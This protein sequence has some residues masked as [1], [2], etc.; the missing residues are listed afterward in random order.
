MRYF[1]CLLISLSFNLILHSQI[2]LYQGNNEALNLLDLT[3]N[4]T[5]K[6][7]GDAFGKLV[8]YDLKDDSL[9]CYFQ[10]RGKLITQKFKSHVFKKISSYPILMKPEFEEKHIATRQFFFS[11]YE[12]NVNGNWVRLYKNNKIA[13]STDKNLSERNADSSRIDYLYGFCHPQ[14]SPTLDKILLEDMDTRMFVGGNNRIYEFDMQ[15]GDKSL[16]AK[17]K[18]ASYSLNGKYILY[19]DNKF[20]TYYLLDKLTKKKLDN[21]NGA[22]AAFWLYH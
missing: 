1:F 18:N 20:D 2:L 12:L 5:Q 14:I 13:W 6:L 3:A 8:G 17:G 21:L 4:Q 22:I 11:E 10:I 19:Q 9:V 15:T 7:S 16:I